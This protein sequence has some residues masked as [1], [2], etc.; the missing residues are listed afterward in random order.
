MFFVFVF[1]NTYTTRP[2]I[3]AREFF[4]FFDF[5]GN[6]SMSLMEFT[7]V[8]DFFFLHMTLVGKVASK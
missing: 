4:R 5:E 3:Q 6:G 8:N 1:E 2:S 7:W